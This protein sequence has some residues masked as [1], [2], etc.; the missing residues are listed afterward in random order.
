MSLEPSFDAFAAAYQS[1]RPQVVWTRLIDDL[2]LS[3]IHI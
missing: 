2:E 3:L 1:G